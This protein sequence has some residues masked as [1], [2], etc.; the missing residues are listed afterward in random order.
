M[1]TKTRRGNRK[2]KEIERNRL[3]E[4]ERKRRRFRKIRQLT[5]K[6]KKETKTIQPRITTDRELARQIIKER[7]KKK[8]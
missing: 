8:G 4:N 6:K 3:T 7:H 1:T 2:K 5:K